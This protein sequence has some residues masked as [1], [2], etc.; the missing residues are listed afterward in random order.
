MSVSAR[1]RLSFSAAPSRRWEFELTP[2]L[3]VAGRAER[4]AVP[5]TSREFDEV[6]FRRARLRDIG[7]RPVVAFR[8]AITPAGDFAARGETAHVRQSGHDRSERFTGR[9]EYFGRLFL[10]VV[11]TTPTC[12]LT[13]WGEGAA[14]HVARD[15]TRKRARGRFGGPIIGVAP[16]LQLP[17]DAECAHVVSGRKR[18]E[19]SVGGL[20]GSTPKS[21]P[22]NRIFRLG[23]TAERTH[24]ASRD[25]EQFL[26]RQLQQ[27]GF[28]APALNVV[29]AIE[30][31]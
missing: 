26:R 12:S 3:N 10:V 25:G 14:V 27:P 5:V 31:A 13:R 1:K 24:L 18:R 16:A 20:L 4:A 30:R 19:G 23:E 22:A 8:C 28:G 21:A 6:P 11:E 29:I 17:V 9:I 2:T 7:H 15:Q